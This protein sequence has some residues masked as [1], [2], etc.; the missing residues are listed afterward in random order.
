MTMIKFI[1]AA[2]FH[3]DSPFRALPADKAAQRRAE[4][5][6]LLDRLGRLAQERT[7]DLVLLS[8]DLLDGDRTYYETAQALAR[9]LGQMKARVFIAPGNHDPYTPRSPYATMAWPENVHIFRSPSIEAVA[10]PELDCVVYGCAFTGTARE[11]SPLAGFHA[12]DDGKLHIMCVHG[13]VGNKNS[14]YGPIEA[15]EISASGLH[16]LA[17]GHVHARTEP[18]RLGATVWAYPGCPEG[19]GFDELGDKGVLW[20]QAEQGELKLEFVRLCRRRYQVLEVDASAD[21]EAALPR[22]AQDDSYRI[23]LTG[24]SGVEGID[25]APLEKLAAQYFY[26]VALRD[27]TKIRRD[28]WSRSGEDTLTGLFLRRMAALRDG[29]GEDR[30]PALVEQAVRFAL[31]ALEY[32]EDCCP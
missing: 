8:G 24:E 27:E 4:Q 28:L 15:S 6:T 30:D 18:A 9:V 7:A 12:A 1:H 10:L 14:R 22:N 21:F 2:D 20:G 11:D 23:I 19:R 17:L 26:S 31:A 13:D 32:G 29:G 16:Y 25:P 3:L 5:R